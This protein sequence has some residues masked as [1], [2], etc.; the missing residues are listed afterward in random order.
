MQ[1]RIPVSSFS[2]ASGKQFI[3]DDYFF[4]VDF[5]GSIAEDEDIRDALIILFHEV[6][7]ACPYHRIFHLQG[8]TSEFRYPPP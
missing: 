5:L 1:N 3:I 2:R 6:S 8:W 4:F 7:E